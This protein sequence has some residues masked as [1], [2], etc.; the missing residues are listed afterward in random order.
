M[1]TVFECPVYSLIFSL[2]KCNMS[3][4]CLCSQEELGA[5]TLLHPVHSQ[6]WHHP[7]D[8]PAISEVSVL[9]QYRCTRSWQK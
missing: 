6:C 3:W 7:G 8:F 4:R 2:W 9:K 1:S 5:P